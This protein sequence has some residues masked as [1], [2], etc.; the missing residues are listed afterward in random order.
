MR[1][2]RTPPAVINGIQVERATSVATGLA[3]RYVAA[4]IAHVNLIQE[5]P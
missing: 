3:V 5:G 4:G 1:H 2:G